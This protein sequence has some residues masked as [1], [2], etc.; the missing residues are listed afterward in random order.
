MND[1]QLLRYSRHILLPEIGIE[2]QERL[3]AA[4]ALIIGAG[5]L[6]CPAA[7][8]LAAAGVG[9]L[10]ISDGD[11]VDLTNLQRQIVYRTESIGAAKV[12]AARAARCIAINPD[13][14]VVAAARARRR[15]RLRAGRAT[16]TW[17]STAPTTSPRATRSTA[18]A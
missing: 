9:R 12:D 6:G 5:G 14:E 8:Y 17:C 3:L 10:T 2:G 1:E 18:P 16:P 11:K 4:H 7:L 13:V 15:M